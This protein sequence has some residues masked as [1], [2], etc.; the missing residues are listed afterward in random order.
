MTRRGE[1]PDTEARY[2]CFFARTRERQEIHQKIVHSHS[3]SII[4]VTLLSIKYHVGSCILELI[5][6]SL[7]GLWYSRLQGTDLA[8]AVPSKYRLDSIRYISNTTIEVLV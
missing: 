4:P 3:V 5:F 7:D 2:A 8:R 6:V 1:T